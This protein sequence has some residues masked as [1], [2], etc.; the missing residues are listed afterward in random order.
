MTMKNGDMKS[1]LDWLKGTD[2]SEVSFKEGREGFSFSMPSTVPIPAFQPS[3]YVPVLS[4]A[5]G[6]FRK[7]SAGKA[8]TAEGSSVAQEAVLGMVEQAR[9][10]AVP[11]PAPRAGKIARAFAS[12]GEAVEF[13]SL[14]FFIEP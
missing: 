13:G 10:K 5:V 1:V 8:G 11:V 14:L 6:V 4:P 12:D 2:L 3:R 7:G 9:G